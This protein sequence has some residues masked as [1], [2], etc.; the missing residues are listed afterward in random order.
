QEAGSTIALSLRPPAI[1]KLLQMLDQQAPH[2]VRVAMLFRPDEMAAAGDLLRYAPPMTASA[3]DPNRL[4]R[5]RVRHDQ[6]QARHSPG[7]AGREIM[8]YESLSGRAADTPSAP[9]F[10]NERK[11]T[12]KG[13]VA[14]AAPERSASRP[15][16]LRRAG[17]LRPFGDAPEDEELAA[18]L[19]ILEELG[20]DTSDLTPGP[21]GE[22]LVYGVEWVGDSHVEHIPAYHLDPNRIAPPSENQPESTRHTQFLVRVVILP[23]PPAAS[24]PADAASTQPND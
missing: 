17:A 1:G 8:A 3:S 11:P 16:R 9:R 15:A 14:G 18:A 4:T 20:V 6:Q 23:P 12:A 24:R 10:R 22:P 13:R 2:G 5:R 7:K 21:P 19:A